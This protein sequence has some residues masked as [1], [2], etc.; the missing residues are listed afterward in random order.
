MDSR[1]L[2]LILPALNLALCM[3]IQHDPSGD[4]FLAF[5]IDFPASIIAMFASYVMPA[6]LAFGIVGTIWWYYVGYFIRFLYRKI[7]HPSGPGYYQ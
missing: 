5:L 1:L 3:K 2:L 4:W 7:T 6:V